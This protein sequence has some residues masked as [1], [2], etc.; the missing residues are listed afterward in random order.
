MKINIES[1]QFDADKKLLEFI[2]KKCEKLLTFYKGIVDVE[3]ILKL[4]N[5]KI[6]DDGNKIVEIKVNVP[7]KTL[8]AEEQSKTFETGVEQCIDSLSKQLI[9]YKEKVW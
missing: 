5:T 1:I 6:K 2:N 4:Q 8:F 7:S 9:K 3:V